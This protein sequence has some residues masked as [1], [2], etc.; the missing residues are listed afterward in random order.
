MTKEPYSAA[1]CADAVAAARLFATDP[2]GFG[3]IVLR[4]AAGPVRDLWVRCALGALHDRTMVRRVPCNIDD[5]R[6][7]GGLD[8]G[9]TL[10]YGRPVAMPGVLEQADGGV[11][12]LSMAERISTATAAR[13]AMVMD[14][15]E[16]RSTRYCGSSSAARFGVIALDEGCDLDERVPASLADRLAFHIDLNDVPLQVAQAFM[17][18]QADENLTTLRTL[19]P[20]VQIDDDMMHAVCAAAYSLGI[21][22]SRP[23]IHAIRAARALA[24]LEGRSLCNREDAGAAARLVLAPRAVILPTKSSETQLQDQ[25]EREP[26]EDL[27]DSPQPHRSQQ[28]AEP[29]GAASAMDDVVLEAAQAAIP[30]GV[31][32]ALTAHAGHRRAGGSSGRSGVVHTSQMRG[33]PIGVRPGKPRSGSRLNALATLRAAAPWQPIR[34]RDHPDRSTLVQIHPEDFRVT[35]FAQ[36]TQ[37]TTIFALD[38][39]GSAALHRLAEAK[40]A[41]ELMLAQ[42][43]VRRDQVAVLAFRGRSAEVLLPPTRSLARAKRSLSGLPGGGATPLAAAIDAALVLAEG[44]RRRGATPT[45]VLL[46]DGRANIARDGT[47]GSVKAQADAFAAADLLRAAHIQTLVVDTS[48][49]PQVAAQDL[50]ARM[51]AQYLPLPYADA[52]ALTRAVNLAVQAAH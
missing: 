48:A 21:D 16:V 28:G 11:L 34:R 13:I 18:W 23:V 17:P 46:T 26:Q 49:R 36:R 3:G 31:L 20:D 5:D 42:C 52:S 41:V 30:A 15:K 10:R 50:A 25:Q 24:A 44:V 35:R 45:V 8:L 1:V 12:V 7:L 32:A 51:A 14:R 9:S 33:R 43:Y 47:G 38:A 4:A 2:V 19:I 22:S 40:G 6:L 29:E 37:T 27:P 39:S